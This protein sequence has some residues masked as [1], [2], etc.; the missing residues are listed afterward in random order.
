MQEQKSPNLIGIYMPPKL[1][2]LVEETR[3]RL[4]MSRSRF[5]QYCVTRTLEQLSVLTSE[6]HKKEAE[7]KEAGSLKI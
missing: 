4:G 3:Q 5:I 6:V 1:S 2:E 7:E